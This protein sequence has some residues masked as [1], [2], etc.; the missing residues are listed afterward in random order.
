MTLQISGGYPQSGLR[1]PGSSVPRS[2]SIVVLLWMDGLTEVGM[3]RGK[4]KVD[5]IGRGS[6]AMNACLFAL[7]F[8][9]SCLAKRLLLPKAL[10]SKNYIT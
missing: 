4:G 6:F 9:K 2:E 10:I 8:F 5:V 7:P 1:I 3:E